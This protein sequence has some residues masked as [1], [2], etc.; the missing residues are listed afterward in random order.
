P[1]SALALTI[2]QRR[3]ELASSGD[4]SSHGNS[5]GLTFNIPL[6]TGFGQTYN[7]RAAQAR[8]EVQAA[9]RDGVHLQVAFE[10]W[11][12]YQNL[13]TASQTLRSSADLLQSAEQSERVALGRYKAGVG[14]ILDVLNAQSALANGRLQRIQ[15]MLD[16]QVSR[17]TLAKAVGTLDARLLDSGRKTRTP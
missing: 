8:R 11:Q 17:A 6:F 9:R 1:G 2:G 15:A 10:V 13:S 16:W 3:P 4:L 12:A 7:V 5:I 14:T